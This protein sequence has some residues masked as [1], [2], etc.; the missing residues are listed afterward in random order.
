MIINYNT[1]GRAFGLDISKYNHPFTFPENPPV[2]VDFIIQ[3]SSYGMFIDEKFYENLPETGKAK[4]RGFYHYYS[5]AVP[6]KLQADLVLEL[7]RKSPFKIHILALDYESGYNNLNEKTAEESRLILE[8]WKEHFDGDVIIYANPAVYIQRLNKLEWPKKYPFWISQYWNEQ[9]P[10]KNP[11]WQ[12]N[13]A[14]I[15]RPL[16]D[17]LLY[18]WSADR[19]PNNVGRDFGSGGIV[20]IDLNVANMTREQ[21]FSRYGE[22]TEDPIPPVPNIPVTISGGQYIRLKHDYQWLRNE[23]GNRIPSRHHLGDWSWT[24]KDYWYPETVPSLNKESRIPYSWEML[25]DLRA[26]NDAAMG[27]FLTT[28]RMGV[29]NSD[30]PEVPLRL[31]DYD[32]DS[33]PLAEPINAGGNVALAMEVVGNKVR[34]KTTLPG[35][36]TAGLTYKQT[37]W[38]VYKLTSVSDKGHF[39]L[40]GGGHGT[41]GLYSKGDDFWV[42]LERGEFFPKL[43]LDVGV[44]ASSGL[45]VRE[46]PDV[47]SKHIR[48]L[49]YGTRVKI[50]DY[51]PE[52]SNVWGMIGE[53][54]WVCIAYTIPGNT[55]QTPTQYFTTWRMETTPPHARLFGEYMPHVKEVGTS[56]T[57][58]AWPWLNIRK[59]PYASADRV[60]RYLPLTTITILE[61]KK[62]S[63]DYWGRT[64]LGW[65]ALKYSGWYFTSW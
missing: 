63:A 59:L 62:V 60:S 8:Y 46:K 19:P 31:E 55:P 56:V 49:G 2:P 14:F 17:W 24:A 4:V 43:P 3:R 27:S 7:V 22:T 51:K 38:L 35:E 41:V 29:F 12:I 48:S 10:S 5:S 23:S 30:S 36:S 53:N 50:V 40:A 42:S 44:I 13:T 47:A 18:Q 20:S 1:N 15:N 57:V 9:S 34:I 33:P 28:L 6:W 61:T 16:N 37:P 26:R 52:G 21:F 39:G 25:E 32:P 58:R 64:D 54:E 45:K 65:V 11:G